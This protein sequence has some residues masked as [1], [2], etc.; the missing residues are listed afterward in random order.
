MTRTIRNR[1]TLSAALL[2]GLAAQ[3][4]RAA[5]PVQLIQPGDSAK[6]C[7]ALATEINTLSAVQAKAAKKAE[8]G[9]R[10]FGFAKGLLSVAGPMVAGGGLGGG[11]DGISGMIAQQA[12]GAIQ[13]QAMQAQMGQMA[14]AMPRA[15]AAT[16]A[17][18]GNTVEA[19]RIARL[20][21]MHAAKSC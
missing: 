13:Q 17:A 10:A 5:E 2:A 15:V 3:T 6:T 8:G 14:G 21:Q 11:G 9:R 4:V 7:E 18:D 16:Q 20:T 1:L 12:M 19:Q